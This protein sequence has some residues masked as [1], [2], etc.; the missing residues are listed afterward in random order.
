MENIQTVPCSPSATIQIFRQDAMLPLYDPEPINEFNV[1]VTGHYE[2]FKAENT[3]VNVNQSFPIIFNIDNDTLPIFCVNLSSIPTFY[4][5][6]KLISH[7]FNNIGI[8][9]LNILAK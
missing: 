5:E 2:E 3:I 6:D 7:Q 8:Y 1:T 9:N 4:T